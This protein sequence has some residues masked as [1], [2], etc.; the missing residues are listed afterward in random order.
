[1]KRTKLTPFAKILIFLLVA[2]IVGF[3][4][5]KS[6]AINSIKDSFSKKSE[7]SKN[8][9]S[10]PDKAYEKAA[11]TKKGVMNVSLD[12]WIGWKPILDANGGLETQPGSIYDKLGLQLKIAII[13]DA[14]Q[15]SNALIKGDLSG[16]GYTVNRF[17]FLYPKFK[18][19]NVEV[20]MPYITNTSTGGDGIIA[21]QGIN[22]I[23]DLVGKKIGVPRFSE[24]Q[25]LIEWLMKKS[26]LTDAQIK[27]IRKNMV[28]FDTPD[29]AAKAFF[30]NQLDAAA[31]WQPYLTQAE[32]SSNAKVLFSTKNATNLILDGVVFRKD[33]M[34][35]H[36]N[37]IS[38]FI[39]GALQASKLYTTDFDTIKDTMPMFS[40]FTDD[41][42]KS[43]LGDATLTDC[44][45]NV[46][47]LNGIAQTLFADMSDI[48]ASIGEKS[49]KTAASKLFTSTMI[50]EL[51]GKFPVEKPK[52]VKFTEEQRQEA[53][54]QDNNKALLS[55]KLTITFDT[56]SA[57]I[58]P[59]SYGVL[60]DFAN[61]AKILDGT[62]IQI[63]GNTDNV[64]SIE[65]NRILS[66][67]RAKSIAT[68]L[69]YQ[70]VTP[71]RFVVIGNGPNKPIADN[72]TENGKAANRR[73]EIYFKVVE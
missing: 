18:E 20:I 50:K 12:E 15:S 39:E 10:N 54:T 3:G 21:K 35:S 73:T 70:G 1:M 13:N 4:I 7:T 14:T 63:E 22:R 23:E 53:K 30:G 51:T 52:E 11:E 43:M 65:D 59:Q 62:I 32:Q 9:D 33:Y 57:S 5:F 60:N 64:G 6:G 31:T 28:M 37:E 8:V 45:T 56:G 49:D 58:S 66:E 16:S 61:T 71:T 19:S 36:P 25:T 34:D 38:K 42:I 55:K 40:T 17:A 47:V 48:W 68:Y 67:R 41:D 72:N 46:P 69:Q 29:D 44:A 26:S 27:E 2:G 24:A